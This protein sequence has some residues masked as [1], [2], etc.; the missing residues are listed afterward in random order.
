MET[1]SFNDW[2]ALIIMTGSIAAIFG[3]LIGWLIFE[4]GGDE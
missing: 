3:G 4:R 2:A 1:L